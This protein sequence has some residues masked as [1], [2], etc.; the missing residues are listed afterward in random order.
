MKPFGLTIVQNNRHFRYIIIMDVVN[1][2]RDLN[3]II[4]LRNLL[5]NTENSISAKDI[6]TE[7]D[8]LQNSFVD[9]Y[10]VFLDEVLRDVHDEICPDDQ[11]EP[12]THYLAQ[13]YI[14]T[15]NRR[16]GLAVYEVENDQGVGVG[17][18]D[19]PGKDAKLVI[20][21]NPCR[22]MLL[23]EEGE[24]EELWRFNEN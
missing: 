7:L 10:G 9:N 12:L 18:D 16:D 1:L 5:E 22:I 20:I 24:R 19:Y 23:I 3:R 15:G 8:E 21:P 17:V 4:E 6:F 14:D 11:V 13:E 2:N